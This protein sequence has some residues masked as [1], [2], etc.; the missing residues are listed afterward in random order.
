MKTKHTKGK[1]IMNVT[2]KYVQSDNNGLAIT[3]DEGI[4]IAKVSYDLTDKDIDEYTANAKLIIASPVMLRALISI[5]TTIYSNHEM[6]KVS[7]SGK[8]WQKELDE[9]DAVINSA[10]TYP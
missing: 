9:I 2:K 10:T 6:N 3:N 4:L 1:W 7:C 5:R 8:S